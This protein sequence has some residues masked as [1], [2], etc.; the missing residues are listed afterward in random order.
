MWFADLGIGL[1]TLAVAG[2]ALLLAL[3]VALPRLGRA[4]PALLSAPARLPLLVGGG[5]VALLFAGQAGVVDTVE[6]VAG[7]GVVDRSVW[8][9]FVAHRD[10]TATKLMS[11]ASAVGGTVG[12]A[13]LALV[14]AIALWLV[15]R[16]IEAALVVTATVGAGLLTT[17]FKNLYGRARPPVADRLAVETNASLPSG[18]SLGSMV[19]LGVLAAVVVLTARRTAVQVLAVAAAATGI[20]AIGVSRL[21]LGVHWMTDVLT[22]WLLGGAWLAMCVTTL[23]LLRQA[24]PPTLIPGTGSR[25]AG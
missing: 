5:A 25:P 6:D 7:T 9:W 12:M 2:W 22:G 11:A 10:P 17:G 24:T 20:A 14:A 18:H 13:A 21:Y 4:A 15:R 1:A 3:A 16:R 19:V 23:V 8:T